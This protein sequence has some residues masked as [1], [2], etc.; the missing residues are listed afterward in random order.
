[1]FSKQYTHKN[2]DASYCVIK[3]SVSNC[4]YC[5]DCGHESVILLWSVNICGFIYRPKNA[6]VLR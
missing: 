3:I 6:S 1:M 2:K 4:V 5:K